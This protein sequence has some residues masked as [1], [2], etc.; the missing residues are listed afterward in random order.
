MTHDGAPDD[1]ADSPILPSAFLGR[2]AE[3]GCAPGPG[4]GAPDAWPPPTGALSL[5]SAHVL[6]GLQHVGDSSLQHTP[7]QLPFEGPWGCCTGSPPTAAATA[8]A[9]A[10]VLQAAFQL[11][12]SRCRRSR[13][14][15][16]AVVG[17]SSLQPTT[18]PL[19]TEWRWDCC[20][21]SRPTVALCRSGCSSCPVAY[22]AFHLLA[23]RSVGH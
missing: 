22:H 23:P 12:F 6:E 19:P 3:P 9:T 21:S 13:F 17:D 4:R 2:A 7:A 8:A 16:V 20:T 18:A 5:A 10:V 14:C 11:L 15:A 1:S